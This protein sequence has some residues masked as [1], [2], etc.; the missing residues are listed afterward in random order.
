MA[1]DF[2]EVSPSTCL[3]RIENFTQ[4]NLIESKNLQVHIEDF[5]Q[6]RDNFKQSFKVVPYRV[7]AGLKSLLIGKARVCKSG[8]QYSQVRASFQSFIQRFTRAQLILAKGSTCKSLPITRNDLR[9]VGGTL[10][11]DLEW[12][13]IKRLEQEITLYTDGY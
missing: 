5:P 13:G 8:P 6:N 3:G 4:G 12:P 7:P 10:W 2:H 1:Y 9:P 11:G